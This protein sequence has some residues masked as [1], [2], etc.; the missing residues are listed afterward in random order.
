[1]LKFGNK[2]FRNLEEQVDKNKQDIADLT[3]GIS[4]ANVKIW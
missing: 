4:A 3:A 1:M 2:E